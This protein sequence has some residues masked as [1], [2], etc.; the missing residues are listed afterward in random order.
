MMKERFIGI[1]GQQSSGEDGEIIRIRRH[2]DHILSRVHALNRAHELIAAHQHIGNAL[3]GRAIGIRRR[4]IAG[5]EGLVVLMDLHPARVI[6]PLEDPRGPRIE[7]GVLGHDAILA[8]TNL[9]GDNGG[10]LVCPL[11]VGGPDECGQI[12]RLHDLLRRMN[13]L[14]APLEGQRIVLPKLLHRLQ[15]KTE[16]KSL[17]EGIVHYIGLDLMPRI[18]VAFSRTHEK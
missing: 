3:R 14:L 9:L 18:G 17:K 16:K 15:R 12:V 7:E 4:P 6:L 1:L 13:G 2:D 10:R 11:C 5:A 8:Q